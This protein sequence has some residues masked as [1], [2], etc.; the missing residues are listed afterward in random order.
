M[1]KPG[2]WRLLVLLVPFVAVLWMPFYNRLAPTLAD[3]PFF[4]LWMLGWIVITALLI[5]F[6]YRGRRS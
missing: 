2:G 1:R 6:A 5:R 4:Y 3:F